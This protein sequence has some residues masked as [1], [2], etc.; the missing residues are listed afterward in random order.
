LTPPDFNLTST[1]AWAPIGAAQN[2][3]VL[4]PNRPVIVSWDYSVPIGTATHSC[5]LAVVSST[6]DPM[7]NPQTNVDLLVDSEKHVGLRNL[8]FIDGPAPRRSMATIEFHNSRDGAD[9]VDIVISPTMFGGGTIGLLL[10]PIKFA[11]EKEALEGVEIVRL[12]KGEEFGRFHLTAEADEDRRMDG[13]MKRIDVSRLFEFSA[14]H[15]SALRGIKL[16]QGQSLRGI[17]TFKGGKGLAPGTTQQFTVFQRQA[18]RIV[19]GSTYVLR[20]TEK[21]R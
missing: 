1:A 5:L 2:I 21:S 12:R 10:P 19:G 16:G 3:A 7:T 11:N 6:Q 4:E 20:G 18:G 17:V 13:V 15:P 8:H 14:A 9:L